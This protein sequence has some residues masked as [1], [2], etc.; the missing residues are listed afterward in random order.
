MG[1]PFFTAEGWRNY[2]YHLIQP[3]SIYLSISILLYTWRLC[4]SSSGGKAAEATCGNGEPIVDTPASFEAV[5]NNFGFPISIFLLF[6][7]K[8]WYGSEVHRGVVTVASA[9]RTW[10]VTGNGR[11][12]GASEG[13]SHSAAGRWTF[14]PVILRRS[15]SCV[16]ISFYLNAEAAI[17]THTFSSSLPPHPWGPGRSRKYKPELPNKSAPPPTASHSLLIP[18]SA[19]NKSCSK[20]LLANMYRVRWRKRKGWR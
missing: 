12:Q 20:Y 6:M 8:N 11:A 2:S 15:V 5:R 9:M 3:L 19:S 17:S 4:N 18:K 13:D 10:T 7:L 1:F 14:S 16:I